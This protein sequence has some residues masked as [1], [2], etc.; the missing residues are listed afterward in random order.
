MVTLAGRR[1][2]YS[3][4]LKKHL[5]KYLVIKASLQ[6]AERT[7]TASDLLEAALL[8]FIQKLETIDRLAALRAVTYHVVDERVHINMMVDT[9]LLAAAQ[10]IAKKYNFVLADM[11]DAAVIESLYADYAAVV[12]GQITNTLAKALTLETIAPYKNAKPSLE[13]AP[14]SYKRYVRSKKSKKNSPTK[15]RKE[16]LK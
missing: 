9:N 8:P 12:N 11:V 16:R 2:P 1:R 13:S 14:H 10:A 15:V 6:E 4:R 3:V 7:V 5:Y